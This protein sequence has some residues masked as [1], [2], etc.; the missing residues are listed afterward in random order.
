MVFEL[1]DGELVAGGFEDF[2]NVEQF[3]DTAAAQLGVTIT[4]ESYDFGNWITAFNDHEA[5]GW[6]FTIDGKRSSV[7][8]TEAELTQDSVVRWSPA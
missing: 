2:E 1:P 5:D 8:I 6:E 7:G 3:T 4:K